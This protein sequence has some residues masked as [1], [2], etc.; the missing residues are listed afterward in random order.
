M[1][2]FKKK[3]VWIENYELVTTPA[4][5]ISADEVI[6]SYQK[7]VKSKG[8]VAL[9]LLAIL[10]MC[11]AG[12]GSSNLSEEAKTVNRYINSI[13]KVS[14][15]SSE[16]I[17]FAREAYQELN[18]FDKEAVDY[19]KLCKAE[20]A[21]VDCIINALD[22]TPEDYQSIQDAEDE[23]YSLC[24]ESR[25][26]VK[27]LEKL[28]QARAN[29]YKG[30]VIQLISAGEYNFAQNALKECYEYLNADELK[31]FALEISN[32]LAEKGYYG[33]AFDV[34]YSM[35]RDSNISNRLSELQSVIDEEF[36]KWD[37]NPTR[38][39]V[40]IDS[41]MIFAVKNDG[42]VISCGE[43]SS[44]YNT[45]TW[46]DIIAIDASACHV[47]GLRK[48][49]TVVATG[50]DENGECEVDG[51]NGIVAV[52]AGHEISVGLRY[53]GTVVWTGNN[54]HYSKEVLDWD[55]VVD[56]EAQ[57][58]HVVGIKSDGS[59]LACGWNDDGQC[60]VDSWKN[61]I[62]TSTHIKY[63]VGLKADGTVVHTGDYERTKNDLTKWNGIK[64]IA[65]SPHYTYGIDDDGNV[66]AT[67]PCSSSF[68]SFEN[69][70]AV[71]NW[72]N[73]VSLS[74]S[75]FEVVGLCKDGTL[76]YSGDDSVIINCID[77]LNDI[78]MPQ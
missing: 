39:T 51:W 27:Q 9:L 32:T 19:D 1:L 31:T 69:M 35:P 41:G 4:M 11:L 33:K 46:S 57:N 34:L 63:T 15:E 16:K 30:R 7:A 8:I 42:T 59:V 67:S 21:Y 60:D 77:S 66:I 23:Y 76:L 47:L 50:H 3:T 24:E 65:A 25:T 58:H 14:L 62:K 75:E 70:D 54:K 29:F 5:G 74:A 78:M 73:I 49:G 55:N 53:D 36:L 45:D 48:D 6:K 64:N 40:C 43:D 17:S 71:A 28:G 18:V 44:N 10:S 26:Y 56:I 52:A 20:A 72:K 38:E 37:G 61:I 68:F 12:C 22:E 13:G 2:F